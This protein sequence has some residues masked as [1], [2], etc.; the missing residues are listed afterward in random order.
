MEQKKSGYFVIARVLLESELWQDKPSE[1]L[2][3]WIY[4]LEKVNWQDGKR[5]ERGE[6]YFNWTHEFKAI[7]KGISIDQVKRATSYF[8][9]SAM[10]RTTKSTRGMR[11]KVLNYAKYQDFCNYTRTEERTIP[12]PQAHDP[13]TIPAPLYQKETKTTKEKKAIN[14]D[15]ATPSVAENK[16]IGLVIK[17]FEIVN[18]SY[19]KMFANTTQRSACERLL[20]KWSVP[21]IRAVVENV[22]PKLNSDPYAKGKSITPLQLEDNLG[23]IKAYI[24]QKKTNSLI[25][26]PQ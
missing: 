23:Y 6:G 22:L 2:K 12:A 16:D 13:R 9:K 4:I 3:I 18:P 19:Q 10:I 20:K 26:L 11:I 8:K 24:D 14:K 25:D 21:Q 17:I 5:L 15:L 7:G 1:W